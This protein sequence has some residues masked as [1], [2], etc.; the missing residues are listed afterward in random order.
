MFSVYIC[1]C[2]VYIGLMLIHVFLHVSCHP[3]CD[4]HIFRRAPMPQLHLF[5]PEPN[6]YCCQVAYI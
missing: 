4:R 6:T 2:P 3:R 1:I 5:L